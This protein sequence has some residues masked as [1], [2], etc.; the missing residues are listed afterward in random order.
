MSKNIRIICKPVYSDMSVKVE[1]ISLDNAVFEFM[2]SMS[3]FDIFPEAW[4]D[5]DTED[6]LP[7]KIFSSKEDMFEWINEYT[8]YRVDWDYIA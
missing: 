3:G 7:D 2:N 4:Y 8:D 5:E 6:I 1:D